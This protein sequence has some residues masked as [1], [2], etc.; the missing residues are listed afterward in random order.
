MIHKWCAYYRE[1]IAPEQF[2]PFDMV[3]FDPDSHPDLNPLIQ[4]HKDI[5]AYLSLGEINSSRDYYE[6][7]KPLVLVENPNWPGAYIVDVR[8]RLWFDLILLDIVPSILEQGFTGIFL[9]TIDSPLDLERKNKDRFEGMQTQLEYLIYMIKQTYP[10][11]V[12]MM[13]QGY[14]LIKKI[15]PKI[16]MVLGESVYTSYNFKM[17]QYY[18]KDEKEFLKQVNALH[19]AKRLFPHLQLFSLDYWYSDDR[20]M[21]KQ[22]YETHRKQRLT[23]YIGEVALDQ[24]YPE[25]S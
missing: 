8:D 12:I 24:I 22:I 1:K 18:I 4:S 6:K 10:N 16:N 3:I 14:P 25:P 9:D 21:I 15:G 2:A 13:N 20:D 7:A 11:L 19:E 23:P 17:K 5:F